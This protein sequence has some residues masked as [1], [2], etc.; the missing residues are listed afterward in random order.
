M[1][2]TR[3]TIV[4]KKIDTPCFCHVHRIYDNK[5]RDPLK[6]LGHGNGCPCDFFDVKKEDE[7]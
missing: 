6:C 4:D 1:E 5:L 3:N 2:D 7:S